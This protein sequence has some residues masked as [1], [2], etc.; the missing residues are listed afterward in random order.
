MGP[1]HMNYAIQAHF[2]AT[3]AS[4]SADDTV[5]AMMRYC[6]RGGFYHASATA[7]MRRNKRLCL[8]NVQQICSGG[9]QRS[10]SLPWCQCAKWECHSTK[11]VFHLRRTSVRATSASSIQHAWLYCLTHLLQRIPSFT[12]GPAN[13]VMSLYDASSP[14][15]YCHS[16]IRASWIS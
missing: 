16:C 4:L 15:S 11:V 2:H 5:G 14:M 13:A 3:G 7:N 6:T 8:A 9:E 12:K 10:K 1:P